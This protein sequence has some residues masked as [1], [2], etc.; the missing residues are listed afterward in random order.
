MIA[1]LLRKLIELLQRW[2]D[3]IE[4][5]EPDRF[6]WLDGYVWPEEW[7]EIWAKNP[8]YEPKSEAKGLYE[9]INLPTPTAPLIPHRLKNM[10]LYYN[11][12][13]G[14]VFDVRSRHATLREGMIVW[15]WKEFLVSGREADS[16][17]KVALI[18]DNSIPDE[19]VLCLPPENVRLVATYEDGVYEPS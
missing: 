7:K 11:K 2:L 5:P 8:D 9:I 14:I 6:K 12:Q 13:G 1:N 18:G 16:G 3:A 17:T 15:G 10:E 4:K 19:G